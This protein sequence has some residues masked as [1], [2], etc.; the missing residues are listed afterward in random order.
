MNLL[1]WL[2]LGSAAMSDLSQVR[3][4]DSDSGQLVGWKNVA[5]TALKTIRPSPDSSGSPRSKPTVSGAPERVMSAHGSLSPSQA[6][7]I[8]AVA[9]D[10][11]PHA[12]VSSSTPRSYVRYVQSAPRRDTKFTFA[13]AFRLG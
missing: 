6:M 3:L 9:T 7:S 4:S 10:P 8:A 12:K 5:K 2:R 11:D 13:P 1:R